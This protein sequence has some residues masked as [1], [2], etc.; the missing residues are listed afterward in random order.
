MHNGNSY[1]S[2]WRKEKRYFAYQQEGC[3]VEKNYT[4]IELEK[5]N[6]KELQNFLDKVSRMTVQQVDQ[7]YAR[8]PD[9]S[10]TYNG[11]QVYHYA[12]T[13]SFRIHVVNEAGRYKIIRL[14]PHHKVHK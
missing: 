2:Y 6:N 13:D 7:A 12:V 11:L 14:D 3:S 9:K 4:L 1:K 8:R 5:Q 10:D